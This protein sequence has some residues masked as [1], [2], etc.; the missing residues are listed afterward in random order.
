MIRSR[1]P[2]RL[3]NFFRSSN[4][5]RTP[6]TLRNDTI[7]HSSS[8]LAISR[9]ISSPKDRTLLPPVKR[10]LTLKPETG[11]TVL[12]LLSVCR[13]DFSLFITSAS[14]F[15]GS[16]ICCS[17]ISPAS[18]IIRFTKFTRSCCSSKSSNFWQIAFAR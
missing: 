3:Q 9:R 11:R 4:N 16:V 10:L 5:I 12:E 6:E 14:K 15:E 18:I 17:S 7:K 1:V 13:M 2:S 8:A